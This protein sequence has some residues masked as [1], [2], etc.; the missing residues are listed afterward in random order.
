MDKFFTRAQ[1][2]LSSSS[3]TEAIIKVDRYV[4]ELRRYVKI[5]P[6][7]KVSSRGI[8]LSELEKINKEI[9]KCEHWV[10]ENQRELPSTLK[11]RGFGNGAEFTRLSP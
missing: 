10:D 2:S 4:R 6:V 3:E 9:K 8:T 5:K 11:G 7:D 1:I